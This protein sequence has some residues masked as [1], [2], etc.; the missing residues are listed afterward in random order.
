[1]LFVLYR[2]A[3]PAAYRDDFTPEQ[4]S[5]ISLKS[6][7]REELFAREVRAAS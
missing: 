6:I 1:V 2:D 3:F 5:K 7:S 4:L